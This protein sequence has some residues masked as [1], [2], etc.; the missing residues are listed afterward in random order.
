MNICTARR[1]AR[2][3]IAG[4]IPVRPTTLNMVC[5]RLRLGPTKDHRNRRPEDAA[6]ADRLEELK[7][8][9]DRYREATSQD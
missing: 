9:F 2:D 4:L 7:H 1:E 6:L 5:R 8:A 3:M